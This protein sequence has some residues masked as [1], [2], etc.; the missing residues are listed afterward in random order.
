MHI[1][2]KKKVKKGRKKKKKN[3]CM[4]YSILSWLKLRGF[5]LIWFE[6][7]YIDLNGFRAT[8]TTSSAY[9]VIAAELNTQFRINI[10]FRVICDIN[11]NESVSYHISQV[12]SQVAFII[13][14]HA[15]E[16][17]FENNNN[18]RVKN[19]KNIFFIFIFESKRII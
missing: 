7:V 2:L 15:L 16:S 5:D 13:I 6:L 9:Q 1:K 11:F 12:I 14:Q 17:D 8:S 18:F 3:L 10:V 19:T 4:F